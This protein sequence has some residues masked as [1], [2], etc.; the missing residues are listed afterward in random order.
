MVNSP[1]PKDESRQVA[2]TLYGNA[3]GAG[4]CEPMDTLNG[5]LTDGHGNPL[6]FIRVIVKYEGKEYEGFSDEKGRYSVWVKKLRTD[7]RDP[8]TAKL[9]ID[10][11]YFRDGKNYFKIFDEAVARDFL[12]FEKT[13]ELKD[14]ADLI[15][16]IDFNIN[17][18]PNSKKSG[19]IES[20]T[21][22]QNFYHFAP[23]YFHTHEAADF[24]LNILINKLKS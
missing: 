11:S 2:E 12:W 22:L 16:D 4:L 6:P 15:Q 17:A 18:P 14:K 21:Y 7:E 23:I 9:R 1:D 10:F 5:T 19:D 13:I 20:N 24:T 3:E 8:P